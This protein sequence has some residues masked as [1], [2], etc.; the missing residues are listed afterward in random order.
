M[1]LTVWSSRSHRY[2]TLHMYKDPDP[3][4]GLATI[5][6]ILVVTLSIKRSGDL[7]QR[8]ENNGRAKHMHQTKALNT[9]GSDAI[10]LLNVNWFWQYVMIW[11]HDEWDRLTLQWRHNGRNGVS[12]HQASR[13]FIQPFI[14]AHIKENIKTPRHWPLCGEFTGDRWIPRTKASY[15]ENVSISWCHHKISPF[16]LAI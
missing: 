14:Q 16:V 6:T 1:T 4:P 5:N 7:P 13:L 11:G 15:A 8:L 3:V 9:V 10:I 2:L 12:N